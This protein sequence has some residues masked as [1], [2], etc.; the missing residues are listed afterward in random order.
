MEKGNQSLQ[1]Y[2][3]F[4]K[5]AIEQDDTLQKQTDHTKL[6]NRGASLLSAIDSK[7][8]I[9]LPS[10]RKEVPQHDKTSVERLGLLATSDSLTKYKQTL[11]KKT[12][13]GCETCLHMD[14]LLVDENICS[15]LIASEKVLS[16]PEE[17]ETVDTEEEHYIPEIY[18][19]DECTC[20]VQSFLNVSIEKPV[21]NLNYVGSSKTSS[22]KFD[23]KNSK[24]SILHARIVFEI[25][26]NFRINTSIQ[27]Q[28][29]CRFIRDFKET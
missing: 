2:V 9:N 28:F 11:D 3:H 15:Q 24:Y 18:S 16:L 6:S 25:I 22:G 17:M 8:L 27:N 26:F 10:K 29:T 4:D 1:S 12:S 7:E 19:L 5:N 20:S 23:S 21:D 14:P 13:N